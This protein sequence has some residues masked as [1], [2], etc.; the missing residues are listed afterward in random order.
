MVFNFENKT[1]NYDKCLAKYVKCV[2][3]TWTYILSIYIYYL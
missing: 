2:H 3:V 1:K